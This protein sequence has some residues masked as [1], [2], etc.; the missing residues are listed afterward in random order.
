MGGGAQG[1]DSSSRPLTAAERTEIFQAGL[2][3][4]TNNTGLFNN[5]AYRAPEYVSAGDV[6]T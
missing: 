6:K 1:S 4:I 2:S 5:L 3:D